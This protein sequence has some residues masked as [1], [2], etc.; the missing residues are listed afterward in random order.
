LRVSPGLGA[1]L[2]RLETSDLAGKACQVQN[3][4]LPLTL[5]NY[6]RKKV[7]LHPALNFDISVILLRVVL[8]ANRLYDCLGHWKD[9]RKQ[10]RLTEGKGS[11]QLT[12]FLRFL[13]S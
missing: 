9:G 8:K 7:L 1:P 4:S 12:S 10:G 13:V 2:G 6:G 11:V 3:S 5:V